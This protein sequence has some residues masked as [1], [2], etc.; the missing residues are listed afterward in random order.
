M[1]KDPAFLFYSKD[2]YEGTRMMLPEERA[3]YIDL[4]IYQ[5]QNGGFIPNDLRR[6]SM[7][8]SGVDK[9]TLEATLK[10]KF[11][12]CDKGWFNRKLSKTVEER[13]NFSKK[14][15]VNGI[16]GQFWKKANAS[17]NKNDLKKLKSLVADITNNNLDFL[18][19]WLD[20]I[21]DPK[22]MLE[23]M[24]KHLA[25]EDVIVN[26][27]LEKENGKEVVGEKPKV[28]LPFNSKVFETQWQLWKAYRKK[29]HRFS[30]AS[31]DSE[32]RILTELK[33]LSGDNEKQ[34]IAVIQ[35]SID[36]GWKGFFELKQSYGVKTNIQ[37]KQSK[38]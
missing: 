17:L 32:E 20:K 13:E 15:S 4:L 36:K 6:L 1:A 29:Q 30:Y 5:H 24:L 10:A 7:Y 27:D 3:C 28:K 31:V 35:Q 22:A 33:N 21:K 8:C 18:D 14:Q 16:V 25:N 11:K 34:A 12:L 37:P 38:F 9:A 19:N 2:F 23:A 26:E